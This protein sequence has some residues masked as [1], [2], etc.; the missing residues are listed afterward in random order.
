MS[1]TET[2][3]FALMPPALGDSVSHSEL[4]TVSIVVPTYNRAG[5]LPYLFQALA[6]QTYPAGRIELIVVDNSSSDETPA[7]VQGWRAVL[8]F[9]LHFYRKENKG[10][11]ASRN[12]GASRAI[13]TII[14]FTDSDCIPHVN[15]LRNAVRG[16]QNEDVGLVCGPFVLRPREGEGA[17]T[18]QVEGVTRDTGLYP[19]ANLIV[20][21]RTFHLV[22]GFDER[23]GLYPWGGLVA[24][25]DTDFAWRVKRTGLE[26]RFLDNVIVGHQATRA[27]A[28]SLL[29]KPVILQIFPRLLRTIPELR[30]TALWHRLFLS[31]V[32]MYFYLACLGIALAIA[33]GSAFPLLGTVPWLFSMRH[34]L[35]AAGTP[36]RVVGWFFLIHYLVAVSVLVLLVASVRYRR[37]VL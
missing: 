30:R 14:A 23:Y 9:P 20:A 3:V 24:G 25:E 33:M 37:L 35:R 12:Y 8:P 1:S 28:Q 15:W 29:L 34:A 26:A 36:A 13:G 5:V 11:A 4:P 27:S 6:E 18:G 31:K 21:R 7:V 2:A 10:P 16:F 17:V 22:G 32:H 19:T